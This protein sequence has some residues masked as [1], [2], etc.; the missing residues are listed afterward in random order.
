LQLRVRFRLSASVA[1]SVYGV[2]FWSASK[3]LSRASQ[4]LLPELPRA[5]SQSLSEPPPRAFQDLLPEL[6][7]ASSQSLPGPLPRASQG[8]L[9]E[10]PRASVA[11]SAYGYS[12]WSAS[13]AISCYGYGFRSASVAIL[14]YD[15][16]F[17][18]ASVAISDYGFGFGSASKSPLW[19]FASDR[20][21]DPPTPSGVAAAPGGDF[22]SLAITS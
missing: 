6:P 9:P 3:L 4:S 15:Y 13:M 7:R 16:G 10:P 12:F 17:G 18:S 19:P 5:F 1:I 8:L 21:P 11:I 14:G 2:G 20:L 22:V